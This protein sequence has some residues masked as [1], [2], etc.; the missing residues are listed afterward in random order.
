MTDAAPNAPEPDFVPNGEPEDLFPNAAGGQRSAPV[1]LPFQVP[2]EVT[3]ERVEAAQYE[4]ISKPV[5]TAEPF[6]THD[7]GQAVLER[8]E[9]MEI[10]AA[11]RVSMDRVEHET[12][13]GVEKALPLN[14]ELPDVMDS[15]DPM[16]SVEVVADSEY[17]GSPSEESG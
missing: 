13:G 4:R 6:E 17:A 10:P 14:E 5:P 3:L 16:P 11:E 15:A 8:G 12:Y 2:E 1:V 9:P 7:Q